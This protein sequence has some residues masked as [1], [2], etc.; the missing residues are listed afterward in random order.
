MIWVIA[1][2]SLENVESRRIWHILKDWKKKYIYIYSLL[3]PFGNEI[4][5][6]DEGQ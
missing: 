1:Y 4:T 2:F 5:F 3:I 6:S